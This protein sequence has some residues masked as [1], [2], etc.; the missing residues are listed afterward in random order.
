MDLKEEDILGDSIN[1]HWYYVSKGKA[2]RDFIGDIQTAEL[3]DIGAGSGVF[4]SQLLESGFCERA[5]CL[6]PNYP[7]EKVAIQGK[8]PIQFVHSIEEVTQK[9]VLMVDVIEH[10]PD[11]V[12]FLRQYVR[13]MRCEGYV[14][15]SVPA[16]QFLWSRHDVF[17][18]HHRRYTIDCIENVVRKAGLKP[19]KSRYFFGSL[20]PV[21]A[22]I[23]LIKAGVAKHEIT[24]AQ[25]DLAVYPAW[26]N[27]ALSCVHDVERHTIFKWN[28]LFGLSVFCLCR[29]V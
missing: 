23:R 10:L 27:K 18:E 11:D 22:L 25:S 9:L 2:I 26:L 1:S 4:L 7:D 19:V 6:D 16:F 12:D 5:I 13:K 21:I 20:F 29:K 8:E 15:I 17:L 24:K 28:K 3:L 14:F